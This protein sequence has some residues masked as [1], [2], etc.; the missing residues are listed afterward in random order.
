MLCHPCQGWWG[1]VR[2]GRGDSPG[3]DVVMDGAPSG[4]VMTE[5]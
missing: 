2:G 4:M 1:W 3:R 5:G